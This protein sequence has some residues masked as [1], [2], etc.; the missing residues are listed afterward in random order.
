[1]SRKN[2]LFFYSKLPPFSWILFKNSG[3]VP[4][5]GTGRSGLCEAAWSGHWSCP[6]PALS[7]PATKTG[8]RGWV[9]EWSRDLLTGLWLAESDH[10]TCS[11][12]S[13]WPLRTQ[14]P[15]LTITI[16]YPSSANIS[17]PCASLKISSSLLSKDTL[18]GPS[19][20]LNVHH[21]LRVELL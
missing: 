2:I 5:Q 21:I 17:R 14:D 1:M 13:D 18:T 12:A 7:L 4:G 16:I 6:A 19:K 15:G 3:C 10:K 9:P 8:S 20:L 11:L